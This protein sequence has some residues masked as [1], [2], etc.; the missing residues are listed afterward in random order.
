MIVKTS[1][2]STP[3]L[4]RPIGQGDIDRLAY[5]GR[6]T[7]EFIIKQHLK[8]SH[9]NEN[10]GELDS[11]H[12]NIF[13]NAQLAKWTAM[14][15]TEIS[16]GKE[17]NIES[18]GQQKQA[19]T[20]FTAYVEAL[21]EEHDIS[22]IEHWISRLI[23]GEEDIV[24]VK[25]PQPG[26]SGSPAV[27][28]T[29]TL[30]PSNSTSTSVSTMTN[31]TRHTNGSPSI[32]L[33]LPGSVGPVILPGVDASAS[34]SSGVGIGV[35]VDPPPGYDPPQRVPSGSSQLNLSPDIHVT[36]SVDTESAYSSG[37]GAQ[38]DF[39]NLMAAKSIQVRWVTTSE[40]PQNDI[41][42]EVK[43]LHGIWV[44]GRGAGASKSRA[45]E[46]AAADALSRFEG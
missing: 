23:R 27:D 29:S 10:L 36:D 7:L 21:L 5:F 41:R 25:S 20:M 45:R 31:G 2:P 9:P 42:W 18:K 32:G 44:V 1:P 38:N 16:G 13:C 35:G 30:R 40:G 37:P 8:R 19:A 3:G 34:T 12:Q 11:R 26:D 14:Y 28:P 4:S 15:S 33:G 46:A 43:I 24:E 17:W 39:N 6:G 22:R